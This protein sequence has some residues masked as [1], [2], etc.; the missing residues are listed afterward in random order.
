[1]AEA[2]RGWLAGGGQHNSAC[3]WVRKRRVSV[4]LPP[5]MGRSVPWQV[6][7]WVRHHVLRR[8][9]VSWCVRRAVYIAGKGGGVRTRVD[10]V[11]VE[12]YIHRSRC[13][14]GGVGVLEEGLQKA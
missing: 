9:C 14:N 4:C 10:C 3:R 7:G 8:E 13:A 11:C 2:E 6:G 12:P 1:M 5:R